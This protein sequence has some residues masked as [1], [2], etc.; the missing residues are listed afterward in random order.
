MLALNKPDSR[1]VRLMSFS[2]S[3]RLN[4]DQPPKKRFFTRLTAWVAMISGLLS[5]VLPFI[6]DF[7][8]GLF[9]IMRQ[10]DF[11]IILSGPVAALVGVALGLLSLILGWKDPKTCRL[12]VFGILT[13]VVWFFVAVWIFFAIRGMT[14]GPR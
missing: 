10:M 5:F 6:F 12:A 9:G 3:Q 13:G 8:S 11:L 4:A 7:V 1:K 2:H 14:M